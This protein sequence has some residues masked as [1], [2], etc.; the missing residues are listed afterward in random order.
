MFNKLIILAFGALIVLSY[1][2]RKERIKISPVKVDRV[3]KLTKADA[4]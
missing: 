3:Y 4:G 1:K 2:P